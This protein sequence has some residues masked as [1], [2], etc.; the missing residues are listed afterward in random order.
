MLCFPRKLFFTFSTGFSTLAVENPVRYYA[1]KLILFFVNSYEYYTRVISF[2]F[3][4]YFYIIM[5]SSY[6]GLC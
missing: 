3:Y 6:T 5:Y 1:Q 4:S 2:I